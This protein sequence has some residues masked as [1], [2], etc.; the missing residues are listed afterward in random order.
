MWLFPAVLLVWN[1]FSWKPYTSRSNLG[2]AWANYFGSDC[3]GSECLYEVFLTAPFFTSV[4]YSVGSIAMRVLTA[5]R[6]SMGLGP[7][8][9]R[10]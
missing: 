10:K 3:D 6:W 1:V 5:A 9:R 4:A 7:W 8:P 2:D